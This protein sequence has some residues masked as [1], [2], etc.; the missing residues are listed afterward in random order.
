MFSATERRIHAV[1][2]YVTIWVFWGQL[3]VLGNACTEIYLPPPPP[4]VC[5]CA[6]V[7]GNFLG[8]WGNEKFLILNDLGGG[9]GTHISSSRAE[10]HKQIKALTHFAIPLS[11]CVSG[12]M[13]S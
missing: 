6:L 3:K 2:N 9:G 11:F 1:Y 13:M 10:I 7:G 12:V 8:G 5:F 4:Q